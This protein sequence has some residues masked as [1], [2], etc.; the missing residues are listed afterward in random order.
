MMVKAT[1]LTLMQSAWVS[2]PPAFSPVKER[3]VGAV[4][5][6]ETLV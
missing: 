2:A 4:V 6:R 3:M 5:G 1:L